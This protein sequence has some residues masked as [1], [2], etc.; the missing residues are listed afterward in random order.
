MNRKQ[1][2]DLI[3][4]INAIA[5]VIERAA[6]FHPKHELAG[7][8]AHMRLALE[9]ARIYLADY[10]LNLA[11][12]EDEEDALFAVLGSKPGLGV[13]ATEALRQARRLSTN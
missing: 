10:A 7:E 11:R 2:N 1:V 12:G 4:A 9:L 3:V 13:A 5:S 8:A 6:G